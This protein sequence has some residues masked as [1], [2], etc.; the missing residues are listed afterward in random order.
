MIGRDELEQA[1]HETSEWTDEE[2]SGDVEAELGIDQQ[3][4]IEVATESEAVAESPASLLS[5]IYIGVR[6]AQI[7]ADRDG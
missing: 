6:A 7:A 2:G 4:V 5:G 1:I 3:A